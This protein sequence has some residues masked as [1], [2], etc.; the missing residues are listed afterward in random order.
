MLLNGEMMTEMSLAQE[1]ISLQRFVLRLVG[2]GSLAD[3]V[4]QEA[5]LRAHRSRSSFQGR[6]KLGTWL[7]AIA[8]NVAYDHF[9]RQAARKE[10]AI[11]DNAL[12]EIPCDADAEHALMQH[13]MGACIAAHL[14]RLPERQRQVLALHDM[15]DAK[16][17]EI[18]EVLGLSE[19]NARVLLHRARIALRARLRQSCQL[20]FGHD[21]IPCTPIEK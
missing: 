13:E 3:D 8:V 9:R 14:M 10:V 20:S 12:A 21:A 1:R 16:H 5:L 19:E 11:D 18:A 7:A 2:D 17:A 15:N 6:A 4:V